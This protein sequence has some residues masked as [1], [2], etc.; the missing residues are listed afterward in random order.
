MLAVPLW[1]LNEQK[2]AISRKFTAKSWK[3]ALDFINGVSV[4]AEEEA[5]DRGRCM[6]LSPSSTYGGCVRVHRYTMSKQS[7]RRMRRVNRSGWMR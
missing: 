5:G 6:M 7:R 2:S 3:C 1:R 4:V